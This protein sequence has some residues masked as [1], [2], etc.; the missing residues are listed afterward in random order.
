M[1]V[2]ASIGHFIGKTIGVVNDGGGVQLEILCI[3]D[4]E[5]ATG[6]LTWQEHKGCALML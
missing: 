5:E 1:R 6:H 2:N 4:K 3:V